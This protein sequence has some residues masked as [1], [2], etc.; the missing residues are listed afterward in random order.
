MSADEQA[1]ICRSFLPRKCLV[2]MVL[3]F[4]TLTLDMRTGAA[5]PATNP[6]A[7][8]LDNSQEHEQLRFLMQCE[9]AKA[10]FSPL[11]AGA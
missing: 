4:K 2:T 8:A 9:K 11:V 6:K 3:P 7:N 1:D 5:T 10:K